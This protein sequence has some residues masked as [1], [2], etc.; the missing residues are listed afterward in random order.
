MEQSQNDRTG[1]SIVGICTASLVESWSREE[2]SSNDSV[3]EAPNG[4]DLAGELPAATPSSD[5]IV[6]VS[7]ANKEQETKAAALS[8]QEVKAKA[9]FLDDYLGRKDLNCMES[10]HSFKH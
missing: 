1:R 2:I 7:L 4:F 9:V 3:E 6:L 10:S 5:R 8:T